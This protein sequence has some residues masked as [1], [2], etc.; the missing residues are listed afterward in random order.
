MTSGCVALDDEPPSLRDRI[1]A[2]DAAIVDQHLAALRHANVLLDNAIVAA[3]KDSGDELSALLA[4]A[5]ARSEDPD[6][7]E[8]DA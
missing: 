8:D 2:L 4:Q 1:Q 6:G 3:L 7:N 5:I